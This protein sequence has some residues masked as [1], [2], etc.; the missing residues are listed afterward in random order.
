MVLDGNKTILKNR[1]SASAH[2]MDYLVLFS[3]VSTIF[4]PPV[5]NSNGPEMETEQK[6]GGIPKKARP[7]KEVI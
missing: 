2:K 3:D 1:F 5:Q 6:R 4:L 7:H